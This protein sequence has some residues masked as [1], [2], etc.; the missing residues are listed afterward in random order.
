MAYNNI[1]F[2]HKALKFICTELFL[3]KIGICPQNLVAQP[4]QVAPL[5]ENLVPAAA[6]PEAGNKLP[7]A[8]QAAGFFSILRL[9]ITALKRE[10]N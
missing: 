7:S 9:T 10:L 2:V 5:Q 6:F 8:Y 1:L 4:P 3:Q